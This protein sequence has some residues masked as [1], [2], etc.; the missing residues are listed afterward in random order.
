M[1]QRLAVAT[2]ER[3]VSEAL[4]RQIGISAAAVFFIAVTAGLALRVVSA[5]LG[6]IDPG[7][8]GLWRMVAAVNWAENPHWQGLTGIWPPLHFYI[9]GALLKVWNEPIILAKVFN[10]ACG[11]ASIFAFR[12]AIR[13][14]FGEMTASISALLL[15]VYWTHIWL[16]SSYW[17]EIPY[18]LLMFLAVAWAMR[19]RESEEQKHA[20]LSGLFLTLAI[21]LRHEALM[22]FGVFLVW[23]WL[24]VREKRL[25]VSFAMLPACAALWNLI[26]PWM[27]GRSYFEYAAAV[28]EMKAGENAALGVTIIDCLKQW[29]MMPA[30]VPSI[31][32]VG[33]GLFGL[34]KA[35]KLAARDLFAWMFV[36]QVGFG[37]FM[38]VAFTW[39]P[40]LRYVMLYFVNLLPY[41]ALAWGEV[42]R[43]FPARLAL[44]AL[45]ALTVVTQAGGWWVGRNNKMEMG[46][47]PLRVTTPSQ[48]A[49]DQWMEKNRSAIE[50]A[51]RIVSIVGSGSFTDPWSIEHSVMVN[52]LAPGSVKS[53]EMNVA[54]EQGVMKGELP[55]EVFEADRVLID[56]EA[57][58]YT[59]VV[60]ALRDKKPDVQVE[61][62]HPHIAVLSSSPAQA[63]EDR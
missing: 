4:V 10:L 34:W 62:I 30:V 6:D 11:V 52:R 27:N 43:R 26:E 17:V 14:M 57:E 49:L 23:Y 47:L 2:E 24:N 48:K 59:K 5:V 35:R 9:L 58:F 31:F 15:A 25:V 19:A 36:I 45:L 61:E 20:L 44:A 38:T 51:P 8:D 53:R 54:Y 55:A 40:Q 37:L 21:L 7:G 12:A 41:A 29:V 18:L 56:P 22:L 16:T 39:R 42:M 32:V 46:W 13:P 3:R 50:A 28:G 1:V 33:A 63:S 60:A